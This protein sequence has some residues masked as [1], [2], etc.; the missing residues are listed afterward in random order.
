MS[1]GLLA[2]T[3]K[4]STLRFPRTLRVA[5]P[6][7][8]PAV[9]RS[10]SALESGGGR[11]GATTPR[12]VLPNSRATRGTSVQALKQDPPIDG[13]R[14]SEVVG[15]LSFALDLT[16]GQ[17]MGHSVRSTLI[18]MRIGDTLGLTDEQKSALYYALLLKDL[19]CSSNAARLTSLFGADDRLLK[20]AHKLTDWT[21]G[22]GRAKLAFKFSVPGKSRLAKAWHLLMLGVN[23]RGSAHQMMQQRCERG[24]DIATLLQLPRGT[25]EAIRTLDEHWDGN[26]LPFGL[27]GS[28]IPM[29]GRIV[30]L[31][32]TVEVFQNAFDVRTAYE[33]AHARRGRWFDPV[34]VDCLDAFQMDSDFWGRLRTTDTLKAVSALEPEERV[35]VADDARLDTVAEAFARVIDAKSP[36]T[37]QHSQ[38]VATIAVT[39]A[40]AMGMADK[41]LRT[42]KRAALLHDIGKLGVSNTILDKP[43]ALDPVEYETMKQHTRFTLEILKRVTRFRQ[44]AATAAAHH[45]RLNG[46]GY[47]LGLRGEELGPVARMIAVADV[48]EALSADRPYRA[49]MPLNETFVILEKLVREGHLC[50]AAVEGVTATFTGLASRD[51]ILSEAA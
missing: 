38:N 36:Y 16:E 20:H 1:S 18:G 32:Q 51:V 7:P 39:A 34:L 8:A 21:A 44:F 31:A 22:S 10:D 4:A 23:E 30:S 48:T 35:I 2:L 41:E 46:D 9:L 26:G 42:L 11:A 13:V 43:S 28:G 19:G 3:Q 49:G 12:Q 24:A 25:S 6:A 5:Y 47:H 27:R 45:E 50:A 40:T 37:A 29:L 15:A 33:M 17:P 14:L